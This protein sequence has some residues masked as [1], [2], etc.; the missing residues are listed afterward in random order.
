MPCRWIC[1][2]LET[3]GK[4]KMTNKN[5]AWTETCFHTLASEMVLRLCV[6]KIKMFIFLP[7]PPAIFFQCRRCQEQNLPF[8][9]CHLFFPFCLI[10][11]AWTPANSNCPFALHCLGLCCMFNLTRLFTVDNWSGRLKLQTG[12]HKDASALHLT[13]LSLHRLISQ[14]S[15]GAGTAIFMKPHSVSPPAA[16]FASPCLEDRASSACSSFHGVFFLP[17]LRNIYGTF[18]VLLLLCW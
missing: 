3:P 18:Y 15:G 8:P 16:K 1:L 14:K 9:W 10:T 5:W 13:A 4:T 17:F 2:N 12:V 11:A 6:I 7:L